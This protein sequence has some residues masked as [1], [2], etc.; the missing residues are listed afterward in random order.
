MDLI[1]VETTTH[2]NQFNHV[3][4]EQVAIV[5]NGPDCFSIKQTP[6]CSQLI[7]GSSKINLFGSLKIQT[8][9]GAVINE[10]E[11]KYSNNVVNTAI[12]VDKSK[13]VT[14]YKDANGIIF[15]E[16]INYLGQK[17][18]YVLKSGFD[19]MDVLCSDRIDHCPE[20][21]VFAWELPTSPGSEIP[22]EKIIYP[23]LDITRMTTTAN[24]RIANSEGTCMWSYDRSSYDFKVGERYSLTPLIRNGLYNIHE[25]HGE[26]YQY[27]G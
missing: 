25:I 10:F 20:H 4:Y 11:S 16:V 9:T 5:Y 24:L 2:V 6:L 22:I 27:F 23:W 18:T 15:M 7:R 1:V 14:F 13:S 3:N 19:K 12:D 8:L 21:D 26:F 17:Y